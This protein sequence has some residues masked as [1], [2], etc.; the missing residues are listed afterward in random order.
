MRTIW[1]SNKNTELTDVV[2]QSRLL[3]RL[4]ALS[5]VG[6]AVPTKKDIDTQTFVTFE[7]V[8]SVNFV[9]LTLFEGV[10]EALLSERQREALPQPEGGAKRRPDRPSVRRCAPTY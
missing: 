9:L 3:F 6:I 7:T 10:P 5:L 2:M 8:P 1:Q 4:A